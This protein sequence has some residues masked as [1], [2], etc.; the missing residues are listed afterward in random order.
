MWNTLIFHWF[1]SCFCYIRFSRGG[2]P[3]TTKGKTVPYNFGNAIKY[4]AKHWWYSMD[5]NPTIFVYTLTEY[6]CVN[7]NLMCAHIQLNNFSF[8]VCQTNSIERERDGVSKMVTIYQ[9]HWT[10]EME[11]KPLWRKWKRYINNIIELCT[12]HTFYGWCSTSSS[13]SSSVRWL[14]MYTIIW[15]YF[16]YLFFLSIIIIWK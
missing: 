12:V 7:F 8:F 16:I 14:H 6:R 3:W 15:F 1:G 2:A 9:Y 11:R 13:S 4:F 5:I 10:P